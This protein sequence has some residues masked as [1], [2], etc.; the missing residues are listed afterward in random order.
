M[1]DMWAT[2]EICSPVANVGPVGPVAKVGPAVSVARVVLCCGSLVF[3]ERY[4]YMI[5][6]TKVF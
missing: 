4:I 3:L 1:L 5:R 6:R 2:F